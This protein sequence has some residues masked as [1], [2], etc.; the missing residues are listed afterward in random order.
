MPHADNPKRNYPIPP[1]EA[2]RLRALHEL[3][4]L[5]AGQVEQVNRIC[6]LARDLFKVPIALVTLIDRDTQSLLASSGI[7]LTETRREDT[8]CNAAILGD[9]PLV[10]PDAAGDPRFNTRVRTH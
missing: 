7:E 8:L 3:E 4:L 2:E 1:N 5:G 9:T 6:A 10:V